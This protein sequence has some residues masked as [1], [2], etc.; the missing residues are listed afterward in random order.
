MT[1]DQKKMFKQ[2]I[3]FQK[4]TFDNSVNAM[5]TL[6]EQGEKMTQAFLDQAHWLPSEGRKAIN[7]WIQAYKTG[8]E[9]F[10]K[11][12]EDNFSKVE[13]FFAESGSAKSGAKK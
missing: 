5:T 13:E 12:V 10:K 8:R 9:S 6:Q 2:M 3:D 7:D 4:T 11:T 1:M